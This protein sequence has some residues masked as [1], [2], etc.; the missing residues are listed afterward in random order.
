[1][2]VVCVW[3]YVYVS[4]GVCMV[5]FKTSSGAYL[6]GFWNLETTSQP[7]QG[8]LK[9]AMHWCKNTKMCYNFLGLSVISVV[10]TSIPRN[11]GVLFVYM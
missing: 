10:W 2:C 3:V 6:A 8:T 9:T 4:M 11:T 5:C 7:Y 1:M